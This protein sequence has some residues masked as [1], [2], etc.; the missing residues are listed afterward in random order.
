[1]LRIFPV[2]FLSL[3]VSTSAYA[4]ESCYQLFTSTQQPSKISQIKAAFLNSSLAKVF[5]KPEFDAVEIE[6]QVRK[7]ANNE[8]LE[9]TPEQIDQIRT[10]TRNFEQSIS[11]IRNRIATYSELNGSRTL[12]LEVEENNKAKKSMYDLKRGE[13]ET[14]VKSNSPLFVAFE[15]RYLSVKTLQDE[16]LNLK[17]INPKNPLIGKKLKGLAAN[18]VFLGRNYF[19]YLAVRKVLDKMLQSNNKTHVQYAEQA[20]NELQKNARIGANAQLT[21]YHPIETQEIVDYLQYN[22]RSRKAFNNRA[23]LEEA[24]MVAK[25]IV[26]G[27]PVRLARKAIYAIP[28]DI[29]GLQA[30][31]TISDAIGISYDLHLRD[32][33]LEKIEQ[34]LDYDGDAAQQW[35]LLK[36]ANNA[37]ER[38]DELLVYFAQLNETTE[39]WYAIKAVAKEKSQLNAMYKDFYDRLE[40]AEI[41]ALAAGSRSLYDQETGVSVLAKLALGGAVGVV[42]A[43][44]Y[45]ASHPEQFDPYFEFVNS[46]LKV[47]GAQ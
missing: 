25:L 26:I 13:I 6:Q 45:I 17:T 3:L 21:V 42:E 4:Q 39:S 11:T 44:A 32:I 24:W 12:R 29:K 10:I 9:L 33:Y 22:T 2:L 5:Q 16:I 31:D 8:T 27:G 1:M 43:N 38:K 7:F 46:I 37:S 40:K 15:V 30:R 19:K 20:L 14:F 47:L 41:K 35:E 34:I 18:E 36:T 23:A 28:I